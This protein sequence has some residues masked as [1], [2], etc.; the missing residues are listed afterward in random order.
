MVSCFFKFILHIYYQVTIVI[1]MGIL[2]IAL[3][4]LF[5]NHIIGNFCIHINYTLMLVNTLNLI[6]HKKFLNCALLY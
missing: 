2:Y 6:K 3:Q 5:T 4:Y 1:K